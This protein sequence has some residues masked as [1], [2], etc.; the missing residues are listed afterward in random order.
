M[1]VVLVLLPQF[2]HVEH[3]KL[4]QELELAR[5]QQIPVQQHAFVGAHELVLTNAAVQVV[6]DLPDHERYFLLVDGFL[7]AH[8][9][10]AAHALLGVEPVEVDHAPLDVRR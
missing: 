8:V 9:L 1:R 6:V 10:A 5:F 4:D 2:L 7:F 3:Q